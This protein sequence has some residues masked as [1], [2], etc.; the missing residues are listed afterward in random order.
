M[1][2]ERP[3]LAQAR[4]EGCRSGPGV[5]QERPGASR[6]AQEWAKSGQEW[7]RN[8]QEQPGP[9][10]E[11][12]GA[13]QAPSTAREAGFGTPAHANRNGKTH[14][15]SPK[16]RPGRT[17]G[18]SGPP[19]SP[20][21]PILPRRT[22]GRPTARFRPGSH[23]IG[24]KPVQRRSGGALGAPCSPWGKTRAPTEA[25][26]VPRSHAFLPWFG[27]PGP[28]GPRV[29][30]Y[31]PRKGRFR[32]SSR[33]PGRPRDPRDWGPDRGS[34]RHE[35]TRHSEHRRPQKQAKTRAF[36]IPALRRHAKTLHFG[37]P[38]PPPGRKNTCFPDS[39]RPNMAKPFVKSRI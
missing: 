37:H 14:A 25:R 36:G 9:A 16:T 32:A 20:W 26:R 38:G 18:G 6:S 13:A 1:A 24:P 27:A 33:P 35:K 15:K 34:K 12:P 19:R 3:G 28:R 2:R 8:A 22:E 23:E 31:N 17:D 10:Q 39:R 4:P 21:G 30:P 5:A 11:R 29:L 7:L